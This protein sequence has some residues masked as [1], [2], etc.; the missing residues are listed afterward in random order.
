[1]TAFQDASPDRLGNE[2]TDG[3]K[4]VNNIAF[5]YQKPLRT[6]DFFRSRT[7]IKTQELLRLLWGSR[8]VININPQEPRKRIDLQVFTPSGHIAVDICCG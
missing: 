3:R 2:K 7:G 1:M 5:V 4:P 6:A 8:A